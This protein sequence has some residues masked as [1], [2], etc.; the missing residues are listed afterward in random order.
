[1]FQRM[2]RFLVNNIIHRNA[3]IAH[4][5][6]EMIPVNAQLIRC[7]HWIRQSVIRQR[8]GRGHAAAAAM[9]H[10]ELP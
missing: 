4:L 1:M 6:I 2:V 10:H 9:A 7:K 5:A 3:M 8:L